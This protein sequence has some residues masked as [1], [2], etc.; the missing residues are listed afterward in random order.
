MNNVLR[1]ATRKSPLAL[2]QAEH[3]K[4]LLLKTRPE[5]RVELVPLLTQG[6]KDTSGPLSDKGGKGLFVKELQR[7][8]LN[9][10]ADMA[11]HSVKDMSVLKTEGL[12]LAA[13]PKRADAR[14]V[15]VSPHYARLSELPQGARVGTSSPRRTAQLKIWRDDLNIEVLRG[16]L[17]TRLAKLE[18]LDF[19]AIILAAAGL[20]RLGLQNNIREFLPVEKFIPAIGQGALGIECRS[21]DSELITLLQELNDETSYLCVNAERAVNKRLGGNCYLPVAAHAVIENDLLLLRG[22]VASLDGQLV[23]TAEIAGNPIE[24][25]QLGLMLAE[26]LLAQ[27]A[28]QVLDLF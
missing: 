26:K 15:L 8:V 19:D 18:N 25:E 20:E 2:W 27:G 23:F 10:E 12:I 11:V 24:A 14:D 6:D 4:A 16:N 28:Q 3:V 17:Q 9:H 1:L 7:A 21:A 22:M 13:I 5:L